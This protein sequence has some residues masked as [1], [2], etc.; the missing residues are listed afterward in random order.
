MN[1]I[2]VL[3]IQLRKGLLILA[4]GS[5]HRIIG[6]KAIVCRQFWGMNFHLHSWQDKAT[7]SYAGCPKKLKTQK[8]SLVFDSFQANQFITPFNLT[9]FF[10]AKIQNSDKP[11]GTPLSKKIQM[12]FSYQKY[13]LYECIENF[14]HHFSLAG[15]WIS[16][17]QF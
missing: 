15:W 2:Y 11:V 10:Y 17:N 4:F 5:C 7:L 16:R 8:Y 12:L 13:F 9:I 3:D 6:G 14:W 1:C